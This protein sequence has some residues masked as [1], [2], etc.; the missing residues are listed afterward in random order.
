MLR[1]AGCKLRIAAQIE[2]GKDTPGGRRELLA[3]LSSYGE[4]GGSPNSAPATVTVARSDRCAYAN[5]ES[6]LGHLEREMKVRL[7]TVF[8]P[9]CSIAAMVCTPEGG[10]GSSRA[11][12]ADSVRA[13]FQHAWSG[14]KRYAWGHDELKPLSNGF[15]DWHDVSL[16]MTPLD[17]FDTMLIMGLHTEASEAKQLVLDNLTF[18]HDFSVQVF[19]ITIRALGGLISA[20]QMDG[21]PKF[22]ELATDLA[23]RLLPAFDSRTGMPYRR[24]NLRTGATEW[25]VSN[26]AEIGTLMLEFGT[27]SKLT[28]NQVYYDKAKRAVAAVFDR[29]SDVGLVGTTINVETGDWQ[30]TE[31]HIGG[32]IDSYYEYLLKAWLLFDDEDFKRMWDE[33][34]AAVNRHL[35]DERDT[36]F[37]YGRS[38]MHDGT[39][40]R[41]VFG[42]LDSFMPAV[43]A[44]S[45]DVIRA[46]RLMESCFSMWTT[47]EI[48][49]EMLDYS[50]M[51]VVNAAYPLRPEALES[52]Y[53]LFRLT[54]GEKYVSMGQEMF[55]NIVRYTRTESGFAALESVVTRRKADAMESFFMAE[56]LKYA[57]LLFAPEDAIDFSGVIFNTE[58]H[59][60]RRSW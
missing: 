5:V 7:L 24:V 12:L 25:S 58:A 13:A 11:G 40:T 30:N 53:Y 23:N 46:E 44:L 39:R 31:S 52:A 20:Y 60:I 14:Y 27:M 57:Y 15:R 9:L 3:S 1:Y 37:W 8:L 35:T 56:T 19:E 4:G 16:Y 41:T 32:M 45:G 48:E 49:P 2:C 22:L 10:P 38:D 55:E 29:R 33:S 42:A 51:E 17:A 26:P 34:I 28:H 36:G 18:D 43:L 6:R 21:D 50:A 54:G 47:F 59:P